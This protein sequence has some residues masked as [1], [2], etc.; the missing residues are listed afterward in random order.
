MHNRLFE[1]RKHLGTTSLKEYAREVGVVN[2][3]FLDEL[4]NSKYSWHV[5]EDQLEA[6]DKGIRSVP[7][8]FINGELFEGNPTHANLKRAVE[9][10]LKKPVKKRA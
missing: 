7:A 5:R 2:K 1:R 3:K 8:I 10:K 4:V 6:W 9:E